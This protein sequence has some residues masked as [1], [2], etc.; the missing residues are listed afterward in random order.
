MRIFPSR[1]FEAALRAEE[2][3]EASIAIY[4]WR[5][6]HARL[7]EAGLFAAVRQRR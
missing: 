6:E 2:T 7:G 4:E 5:I 1:I 3:D